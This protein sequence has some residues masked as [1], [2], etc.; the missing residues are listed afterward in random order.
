VLY[1]TALLKTFEMLPYRHACDAKL[2][3]KRLGRYRTLAFDL[4]KDTRP[5]AS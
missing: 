1:K 4:F 5:P 2:C 3:G